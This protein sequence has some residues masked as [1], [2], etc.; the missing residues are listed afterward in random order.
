MKRIVSVSCVSFMTC[1]FLI[2]GVSFAG[3]LTGVKKVA[4]VE[5]QYEQF[6][7]DL[8]A[9]KGSAGGLGLG[10]LNGK[11]VWCNPK[12]FVRR[13]M[14]DLVRH[15]NAGG[16]KVVDEVELEKACDSL[17]DK[18]EN[19][20]AERKNERPS[21]DEALTGQQEKMRE[22]LAKMEPK[23]KEMEKTNPEAAAKIRA[24]FAAAMGDA[25][26]RI[27]SAP[28]DDSALKE[29][30]EM[31]A[32]Q[33][34]EEERKTEPSRFSDTNPQTDQK[35]PDTE[36]ASRLVSQ[37]SDSKEKRALL[38]DTLRKMGADAYVK[39]SFNGGVTGTKTSGLYVTQPVYT[40]RGY[41]VLRFEVF[42]PDGR[43]L[44]SPGVENAY[45]REVQGESFTGDQAIDML[46]EATKNVL[47]KRM[48]SAGL[49]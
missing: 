45:S 8:S 7:S 20:K 33:R 18:P 21:K 46:L 1:V 24:R 6:L 3:D 28:E 25:K 48:R 35:A 32:R 10:E 26:S 31:L 15:L 40:N 43:S 41:M 5:C 42:T 12:Y 9:P 47:T 13:A 19:Q 4:I 34:K 2:Q 39:A 44:S 17:V 36:A 23:L 30:T 27:E 16:I 22:A 29:Q 38:A 37:A 11:A 49:K 14:E